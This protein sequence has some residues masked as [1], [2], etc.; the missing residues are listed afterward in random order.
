[1]ANY[2]L[3]FEGFI[4]KGRGMDQLS[5]TSGGVFFLFPM[6]DCGVLLSVIK[7]LFISFFQRRISEG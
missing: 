5:R 6:D 7:G 2:L 1:M 3:G 4:C